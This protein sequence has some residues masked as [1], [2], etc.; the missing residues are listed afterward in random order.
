MLRSYHSSIPFSFPFT[1]S[2][3]NTR[4]IR[5]LSK[6]ENDINNMTTKVHAIGI[7]NIDT[8]NLVLIYPIKI[9]LI[10]KS[11]LNQYDIGYSEYSKWCGLRKITYIKIDKLIYRII[12]NSDRIQLINSKPID[13]IVSNAIDI[14]HP[15]PKTNHKIPDPRETRKQEL[16]FNEN[17]GEYRRSRNL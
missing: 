1:N 16:N 12:N 7:S 13:Y 2:S 8:N 10:V 15:S 17:R 4:D 3:L 9:S 11:I 14:R 6:I 5:I